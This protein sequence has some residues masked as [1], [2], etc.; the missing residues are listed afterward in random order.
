MPTSVYNLEVDR[1]CR[2]RR[3]ASFAWR[4]GMSRSATH[5]RLRRTAYFVLVDRFNKSGC[6]ARVSAI[7]QCAQSSASMVAN[8]EI[9]E[10]VLATTADM[11]K[12]TS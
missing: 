8:P 9:I 4:T 10:P 7:Y 12:G 11:P 3:V 2:H 6:G 1:S 5:F